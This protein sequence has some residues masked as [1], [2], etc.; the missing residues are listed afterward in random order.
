MKGLILITNPGSSSRKYAIYLEEELLAELHFEYENKKIIYTLKKP[1]GTKQKRKT[2]LNQLNQVVGLLKEI[3]E[4]EGFLGGMTKIQAILAR[5][6]APGEYFV[7]DH[8]VDKEGLKQLEIGK[9]NAP[10]HIPVVAEE[11]EYFL[12]EFKETPVLVISDS[13]FH[14]DRPELMKYYGFNPKLADKFEIK[15]YGYHGLSVGSVVRYMQDQKLDAEKMIICHIGSG[16]SVTA[17][18]KGK[19]FDTTMGYTPLEGMMMATRAGSMDV[20]AALALKRKLKLDEKEL[21]LFLNKQSGL[22]GASGKSDDMRDIL[23]LRDEGDEEATFAHA[24]YIYKLQAMIGQMAAAL[25][26]VDCLVFTATIGERSD[27]VRRSVVQKLAYLGL[28]LDE[29][30]NLGELENSHKLISSDDSKPIY[31]IKT[32]ETKEMIRR[33]KKLLEKEN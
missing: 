4:K 1:G 13:S 21:E 10:L 24:L 6:V 33:A 30:K 22:L 29:D 12:K 20:A 26:G 5:A 23:K 25:G 17:V 32:E 9:A 2:E 31:V 8:I 18:F 15:R 16:A 7:K 14:D 27:K 28:N 3:L 11:I 19:S